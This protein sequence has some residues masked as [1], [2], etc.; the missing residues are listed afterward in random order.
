MTAHDRTPPPPSAPAPAGLAFSLAGVPVRI[1]PTFLLVV[2]FAAQRIGGPTGWQGAAS[3]VVAILVGV[4]V[5][6]LGHAF[7]FRAFGR[8]PVVVLYALGGL[9]SAR[10]GLTVAR[11]LAV[12]LAGPALGMVLGGAVWWAQQVGAWPD[13]GL[14]LWVL[15][16]DLVFVSVF[17]GLVNLLPLHPLDGGQAFESVL[18]LLR[19]RRAVTVTSIVSLAVAVGAGLWAVLAS[20]FFVLLL[21]GWIGTTNW[22]R[23]QAARAVEQEQ[24]PD[25][26]E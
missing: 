17:W 4:L 13:D 1:D 9:T 2:L 18:R 20:E 26:G 7:A 10:G 23:L 22:R 3:W 24:D 5:H 14:F 21:V 15:G 6:E 25:G 8:R 12:S 16:R 11:D 19:V